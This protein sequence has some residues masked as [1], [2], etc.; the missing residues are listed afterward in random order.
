MRPL[1]LTLLV[2]F[3]LAVLCDGAIADAPTMVTTD[4]ARSSGARINYDTA[5]STALARVPGGRVVDGELEREHG[6]LIWSFD[7]AVPGTRNIREIHVSALTGH[8]L[9]VTTET[10]TDQTREAAAESTPAPTK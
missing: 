9:S 1:A 8:I 2:G 3:G 10:T 5:K 6:R 4:N 7:I